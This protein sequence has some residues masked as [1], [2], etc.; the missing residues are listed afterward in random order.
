M[1][2]RKHFR[3]VA[4]AIRNI[5]DLDTRLATHN[6]WSEICSRSNPLFDP[7]RFKKACGIPDDDGLSSPDEEAPDAEALEEAPAGT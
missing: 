4:E 7:E 5:E 2:T 3:I 6:I 1:L